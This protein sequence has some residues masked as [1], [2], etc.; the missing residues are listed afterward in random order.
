MGDLGAIGADSLAGEGFCPLT[1]GAFDS[2]AYE[3]GSIVQQSCILALATSYALLT[4]TMGMAVDEISTS[5]SSAL[6]TA[7]GTMAGDELSASTSSA[8]LSTPGPP[9][10][11]IVYRVISPR[12]PTTRQEVFATGKFWQRRV[13]ACQERVRQPF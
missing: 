3:T 11:A 10:G 2:L 6:V 9:P 7:A 13:S 12:Q 8:L 5:T 4:S 1:I